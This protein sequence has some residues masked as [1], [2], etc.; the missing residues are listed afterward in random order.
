M[1]LIANKIGIEGTPLILI[2][3]VQYNGD[4]SPEAFMKAF[5]QAIK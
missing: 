3:G 5:T 4:H 2:N 1:L